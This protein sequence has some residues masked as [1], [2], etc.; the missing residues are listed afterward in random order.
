[1]EVVMPTTFHDREQGF[2]AKFAHDEEFYFLATAR[3]DKL[4]ARWAAS[5]LRLSDE[6]TEV[7]LKA[8]LGI[9]N[10]SRHD[11]AVLQHVAGLLSTHGIGASEGDLSAALSGCMQQALQQL[12]MTPPDHSEVI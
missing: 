12:T 2:E 7:L 10:G 5:K 6:A 9:P 3:R 1:M 11:Q 4:F 8:V